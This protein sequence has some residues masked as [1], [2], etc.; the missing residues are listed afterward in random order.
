MKK[1]KQV[2]KVVIIYFGMPLYWCG[3]W[4]RHIILI[5]GFI[6]QF[7]NGLCKNSIL[8]FLILHQFSIVIFI[9]PSCYE[10]CVILYFYAY[11]PKVF[12]H[13]FWLNGE[14]LKKEKQVSEVAIIYFGMP[15]YWCG[16][17]KR[18]IILII[19]FI[20]QFSNGFCKNS[21]LVFLILHQF[22]IV[23]FIML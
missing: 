23:I 13:C 18:H 7:S 16:T 14:I 17:W 3:A 9:L 4:K 5:I 11:F 1:G 12:I 2:S 6:I 20:I 21:I 19:G 15:L 22:S 8:V 10:Q